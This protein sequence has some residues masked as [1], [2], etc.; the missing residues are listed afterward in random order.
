MSDGPPC[1]NNQLTQT[2]IG[3]YNISYKI[4]TIR[5]LKIIYKMYMPQN[6]KKYINEFQFPFIEIKNSLQ[7]MVFNF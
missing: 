4:D 6:W 3:Q 5:L 1:L 7:R 2:A